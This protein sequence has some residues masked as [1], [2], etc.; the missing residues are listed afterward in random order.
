MA[1]NSANNS[2]QTLLQISKR[3]LTV[4]LGKP[5]EGVVGM[6]DYILTE[7][8]A[9]ACLDSGMISA[10]LLL[11][12][13]LSWPGLRFHFFFGAIS[14]AA[15]ACAISAAKFRCMLLVPL[16]LPHFCELEAEGGELG[17]CG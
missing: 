8:T 11:G 13:L 1:G 14:D 6:E 7:S 16:R 2:S 9:S 3:R 5:G 12:H 4:S 17:S 10:S 15:R